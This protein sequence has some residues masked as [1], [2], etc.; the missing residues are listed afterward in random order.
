[1][2]FI[3]KPIDI[4][5]GKNEVIL[6]ED[7]ATKMGFKN[8]D[9]LKIRQSEVSTVGM[10]ETTKTIVNEGEIGIYKDILE[11]FTFE[12]S[13]GVEVTAVGRP[14]SFYFIKEKMKLLY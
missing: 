1:L 3:I 6:N 11:K 13:T 9:R 8:G 5:S 2:E 12:L 10:V 7:D 14:D 4:T